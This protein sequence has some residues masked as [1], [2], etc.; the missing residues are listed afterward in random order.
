MNRIP[1]AR[2]WLIAKALDQPPAYFFEGLEGAFDAEAATAA[3][4]MLDFV[5]SSQ[6]WCREDEDPK[7]KLDAIAY[8][9]GRTANILAAACRKRPQDAQVPA[10]A[11]APQ[12]QMSIT[13]NCQRNHHPRTGFLESVP[14]RVGIGHPPGLD[15]GAISLPCWM[16]GSTAAWDTRGHDPSV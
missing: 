14:N 1:A 9:I 5:S 3:T 13:P 2:L 15:P 6:V 16:P 4:E 12:Q 8:D 11:A 10:V 7:P